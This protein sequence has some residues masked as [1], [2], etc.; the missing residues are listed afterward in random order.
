[1]FGYE[2]WVGSDGPGVCV[3]VG[4]SRFCFLAGA[5]PP[6]LFWGKEKGTPLF[7]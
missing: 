3:G 2:Q 6:C 4:R 5:V 1:V 7:A